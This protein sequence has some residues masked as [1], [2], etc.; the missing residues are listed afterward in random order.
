MTAYP[1]AQP[2][3][4]RSPSCCPRRPKGVVDVEKL[5]HVQREALDTATIRRW[6]VERMGPEDP[7]VR[8]WDEIVARAATAGV[9]GAPPTS[10][11]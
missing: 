1:A 7:R 3:L 8:T 9:P 5:L 4:L 10:G 2:S 11:P 6:L